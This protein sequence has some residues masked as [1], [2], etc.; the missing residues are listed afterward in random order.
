MP[1]AYLPATALRAFDGIHPRLGARVLIDPSSVVIGGV[2]LGDDVSVWPQV[3]IRG[4]VNRIRIGARSNVQDGSVLHVTHIGGPQTPAGYPLTVGEEVTVGHA[5]TLHGCSVGDRVIVGM[6]SIVMD[7]AVVE[8]EVVIAAGSLV[9]P[10]KRLVRGFLYKG[11]P[12]QQVR[13]LSTAEIDYF[14]YSAAHYVRLKDRH[15][16]ELEGR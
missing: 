6:G 13:P 14:S 8:E 3:A 10:G 12:V 1:P 5:V 16:A 15:L 2:E 9:P 4:D 11:S 7:G